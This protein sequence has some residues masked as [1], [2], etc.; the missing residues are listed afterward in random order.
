MMLRS[1]FVLMLAFGLSGCASLSK[2]QCL[3]GNWSDIGYRDGRQGY[4]PESIDTHAKACAEHG[5]RPSREKYTQGY[6]KGI[7]TYCSPSNG[8]HVG[9]AN[10]YYH[11]VC[12][13]DLEPEFLENYRYGKKLYDADKKIKTAIDDLRKKEDQLRVEKNSVVRDTLRSEISALDDL[14]RTLQ[15]TYNH[16]LDHAPH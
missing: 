16:L 15:R 11:H 4:K 3:A 14:L 8:R 13:A 2:E 9:E 10:R 7:R 5:V 1:I 12:P 6:N